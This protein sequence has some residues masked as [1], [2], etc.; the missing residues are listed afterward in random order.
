[1]EGFTED[2]GIFLTESIS[3]IASERHALIPN[4]SGNEEI[5]LM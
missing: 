3:R 5:L 4:K 2:L 1:M